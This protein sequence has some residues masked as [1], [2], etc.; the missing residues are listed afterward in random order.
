MG[1]PLVFALA[2]AFALPACGAGQ[3]SVPTGSTKRPEPDVALPNV[4]RVV[5]VSGKAPTIET[6]AVK[7]Q[8][9]GVH[10]RFVN[11]TGEDLSFSIDDPTEGGMG[12]GAP[13]GTSTHVV[14][15]HPGTASIA[16]YDAFAED[17]GKVPRAPLEIADEDG[18]WISAKLD[19][20]ASFT[21]TSDYVAGVPGDADP[22]EAARQ[23]LASY[24]QP[25][26]V[27]ELAG[28]PDAATPLYRLVR[29]GEVLAV[30]GLLDDGAGGWLGDTVTG[31]S[32]LGN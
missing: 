18:I 12:S 2:A 21:G 5:C 31:C 28:Y 25:A 16:C 6:P 23:A 27:V 30:V 19:C 29:A 13:R 22:L 3:E 10:V 20:T 8:R 32:S 26:D 9:D 4:A 1:R 24:M 15:L 7:S 14:D 17:G 11:E